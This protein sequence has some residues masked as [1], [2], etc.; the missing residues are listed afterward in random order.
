MNFALLKTWLPCFLWLVCLMSAPFSWAQTN[1]LAEAATP[2]TYAC[3]MHADVTA[4][5]PGNCSKCGM[6]LK[7]LANALKDE[8]IVRT[9]AAPQQIKP[10]QKTTLRF[11]VFH[12]TTQAQVKTFHIQH[13]KPFHFFLVSA[14][15]QHFDHLHPT[16]QADGSFTIDTMLP[17]AGMYHLFYDIFPAGGLPQVVHQTLVTSGFRGA[18]EALRAQLQPDHETTKTVDG[19]RVTLKTA[20]EKLSAGQPTILRYQ[21]TDAKSGAPITDL[22]PYLGAWGHTLILSE[23]AAD[24]L[25]SHPLESHLPKAGASPNTIYFETYFPRPGHYRIWSQFQRNNKIITVS[26]TVAVES[27]E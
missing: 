24:S 20:P 1:M 9:E 4:I 16:Q 14:D 15:L 21:L 22:Q 23:D 26:F 18:A 13:E 17:Q 8:F 11:T 6:E 19:L 5:K 3:P 10:R 7:E 2:V 25:H 12:P 27:V